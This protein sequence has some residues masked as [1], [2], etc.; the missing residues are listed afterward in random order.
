[1]KPTDVGKRD[2]ADLGFKNAEA[3]RRQVWAQDLQ[4]GPCQVERCGV[5]V[6]VRWEWAQ[7][8]KKAL[9]RLTREPWCCSSGKV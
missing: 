7:E 9:A 3:S 2:A 6:Q 5:F 1:M 8:G 4:E